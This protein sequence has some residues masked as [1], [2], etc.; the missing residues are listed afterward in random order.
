[1]LI[2]KD[3]GRESVCWDGNV[4]GTEASEGVY[5][6]QLEATGLQDQLQTFRG[7]LTLLR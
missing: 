4:S 6:Y 5:Y 7:S 1:M 3:S 2:L